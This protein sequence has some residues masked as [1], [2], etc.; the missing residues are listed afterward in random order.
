MV[1]LLTAVTPVVSQGQSTEPTVR[2]VFTGYGTIWYSGLTQGPYENNFTALFVPMM[3]F[4][5]HEDLLFEAELDIELEEGQTRVH[6]EHAQ[7]H[8]LG[9]ESLQFTAGMLHVPFGM[10]HHSSW[11]N[12]MPT[13]PLL[14]EDSHGAPPA[15]GLLP[16]L[17]DVGAMATLSFPV[18]SLEGTASLWVSQ[19]PSA[20]LPIHTHGSAALPQRPASDVPNL[21]YGATFE[22]NNSDKLVGARLRLVSSR[23]ITF[24]TAGYRAAY[25]D[26][27][28]LGVNGLSAS[29]MWMPGT[30]GRPLFRLQAEGMRLDQ[31]YIES[32]TLAEESARFG[33]YWVQ[34]SRREGL[35]EPVARWGHF[36]TE[37]ASGDRVL[38]RREQFSVGLNY[39]LSPSSPLKVA[40]NFEGFGADAFWIEWTVGF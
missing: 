19:G 7:V 31:E 10:W 4:Q 32:G 6:L 3:L 21:G 15:E 37:R 38:P 30:M 17:F 9:L 2:S 13:P 1:L 22:D 20:N 23:G 40:Y 14:Y 11:V 28:D 26:A 5:V 18:G 33:G 36:L 27:G 25:D 24:Q 35:F 16:I 8:Y 34:V 39:W 29:V 12:R